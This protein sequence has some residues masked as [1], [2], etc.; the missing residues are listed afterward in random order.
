MPF[1]QVQTKL[2]GGAY[3]DDKVRQHYFRIAHQSVRD[4]IYWAEK[5]TSVKDIQS[6][7]ADEGMEDCRDEYSEQTCDGTD[8][9]EDSDDDSQDLDNAPLMPKARKK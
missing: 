3:S 2:G 5:Y 9:D 7:L 1:S 4:C 6:I 8:S